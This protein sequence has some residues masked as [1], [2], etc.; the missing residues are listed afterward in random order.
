MAKNVYGIKNLRTRKFYGIYTFLWLAFMTHNFI[1]HAKTVLFAETTLADTGMRIL[2]KRVGNIKALV[3]RSVEGIKVIIPAFTKLAK[4][5]VAA[6]T[7]T[8]YVQ[9]SLFDNQRF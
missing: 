7:E 3:E 5:L 2:I 1:V 8:K 6:L 9:L 4:Q